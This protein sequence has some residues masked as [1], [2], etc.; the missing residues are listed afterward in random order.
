MKFLTEVS[1]RGLTKLVLSIVCL[2][3]LS[4]LLSPGASYESLYLRQAQIDPIPIETDV[5]PFGD[6]NDQS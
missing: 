3:K 6:D 4:I 2:L 5:D 1:S